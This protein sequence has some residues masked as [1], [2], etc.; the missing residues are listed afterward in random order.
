MAAEGEPPPI[1]FWHV[2]EEACGQTFICGER[3][4]DKYFGREAWKS[5]SQGAHRVTC[6]SLRNSTAAAGFAS[7]ACATEVAS[8]LPGRYHLFGGGD[9]FPCLQLVWL[10]VHRQMQGQKIGKR[11][12]GSVISTFAEVGY[13]I[14]LPHLVLVPINDGVKP[15][16]R[17]LGFEEYDK[18]SK[19]FLPLQFALEVFPQPQ[20]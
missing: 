2:T 5:H 10:G 20:A 15:F 16:Y 17:S 19:M 11:L 4:I 6:A 8:K 1:D 13:K 3:D 12:V 7:Y 9:R 18:G 14:G